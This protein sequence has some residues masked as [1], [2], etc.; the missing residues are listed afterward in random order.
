MKMSIKEATIKAIKKMK[1]LKKGK[2]ID[3]N[4]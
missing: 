3:T 2:T 1:K 4:I